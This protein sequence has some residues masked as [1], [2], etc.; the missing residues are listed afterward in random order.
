MKIIKNSYKLVIWYPNNFGNSM[1][2]DASPSVPEGGMS[3]LN[4]PASLLAAAFARNHVPMSNEA[5]LT[6]AS[7]ETIDKPMGDKASS[8]IV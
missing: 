8:P 5:N 6:G 4:V 7:F 1:A 2:T 3:A